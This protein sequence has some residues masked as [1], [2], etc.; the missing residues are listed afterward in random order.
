MP[1]TGEISTQQLPTLMEEMMHNPKLLDLLTAFANKLNSFRKHNANFQGG[2]MPLAWAALRPNN[3][4][5]IKL[6]IDEDML[7]EVYGSVSLEQYIRSM[8]YQSLL[9]FIN[10][11]RKNAKK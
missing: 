10:E 3:E 8:G 7:P 11:C 9:P 1:Y 6:L 5:I 4:Q 2:I